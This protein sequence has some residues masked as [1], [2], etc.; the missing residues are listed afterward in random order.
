MHFRGR[1][2]KNQNV[3]HSS[4]KS[5][6]Q[7]LPPETRPVQVTLDRFL[8]KKSPTIPPN[9]L[10]N[11]TIRRKNNSKSWADK[12]AD[13]DDC[14]SQRLTETESETQLSKSETETNPLEEVPS[15]S[16]QE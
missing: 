6:T 8:T 3:A 13:D 4:Q 15:H 9:N 12:T 11:V 1:S 5:T 10:V 2:K 16:V 7:A 14:D